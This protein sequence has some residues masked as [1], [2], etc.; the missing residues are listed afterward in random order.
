MNI[1]QRILSLGLLGL[2]G[3]GEA[4]FG[5]GVAQT[6]PKL[7]TK[8]TVQLGSNDEYTDYVNSLT[9]QKIIPYY[10]DKITPA[11]G[12]DREKL[13]NEH[14]RNQEVLERKL[15]KHLGRGH[16]AAPFINTVVAVD[17]NLALCFSKPGTKEHR[18]RMEDIIKHYESLKYYGK[19]GR[20]YYY[21]F[22][23]YRESEY[24][25][26]AR[27]SFKKDGSD[28]FEVYLKL[29][30]KDELSS[31]KDGYIQPGDYLRAGKIE[32]YLGNRERGKQLIFQ[33]KELP[34]AIEESKKAI[35]EKDYEYAI[36][37]L[38]RRWRIPFTTEIIKEL[39][40]NNQ[41]CLKAL[42]QYNPHKDKEL[43]IF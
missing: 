40:K 19:A 2:L 33:S 43:L 38:W 34:E 11:L 39:C 27:Q 13:E 5:E 9:P 6:L 35:Q 15:Y 28:S 26:K 17:I 42:K 25:E 37:N 32:W 10:V 1:K 16:G 14:W 29:T 23:L 4:A 20:V 21:L 22:S 31:V 18:E 8:K 36:G 24:F 30:K 12:C 3:L 7:V 41:P